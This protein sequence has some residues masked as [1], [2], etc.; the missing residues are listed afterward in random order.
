MILVV[1]SNINAS[2]DSKFRSVLLKNAAPNS[3]S[4]PAASYTK[5]LSV[6]GEATIHF[7]LLPWRHTHSHHHRRWVLDGGIYSRMGGSHEIHCLSISWT[8]KPRFSD[9]WSYFWVVL[10]GARNGIQWSLHVP[11]NSGYSMILWQGYGATSY[12]TKHQFLVPKPS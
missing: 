10:Y 2:G 7:L 11:S 8:T 12:Q 1:F 5:R 4:H 3:K 9:I 6:R